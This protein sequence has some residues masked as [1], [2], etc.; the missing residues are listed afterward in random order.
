MGQKQKATIDNQGG[1]L[2][3]NLNLKEKLGEVEKSILVAS[4]CLFIGMVIG[5]LIAPIPHQR[6]LAKSFATQ[7]GDPIKKGVSCGNNNGNNTTIKINDEE[8]V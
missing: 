4:N 2:K 5:F 8:N 7:R 3:M 1:N 6:R